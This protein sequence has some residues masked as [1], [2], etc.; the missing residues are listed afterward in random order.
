MEELILQNERAYRAFETQKIDFA[1]LTLQCCIDDTLSI[2]CSNNYCIRHMGKEAMLRAG[3][4]PISIVPSATA[5][6]VF[7]MHGRVDSNWSLT[8]MLWTTKG[9]GCCSANDST[10]RHVYQLRLKVSQLNIVYR[11]MHYISL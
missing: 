9:G 2:Y 1:F 7:G 8:T 11:M 5:L 10:T 3:T 6:Q 4:L